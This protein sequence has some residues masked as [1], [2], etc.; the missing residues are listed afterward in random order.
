[1]KGIRIA[2]AV[3]SVMAFFVPMVWAESGAWGYGTELHGPISPEMV[4]ALHL[5]N[6]QMR[7]FQGLHDAYSNEIEPLQNQ[8]FSKKAEMRLLWDGASPDREKLSAMHEEISD[9][10]QRLNHLAVQY[11]MDCRDV[12]TPDQQ[13]KLGET[14]TERH[15]AVGKVHP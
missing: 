3:L 10:R 4:S 7:I 11:Q 12:L 14:A 8:F 6:D 13:A 5:T 1:M 15:G 2:G 9:L